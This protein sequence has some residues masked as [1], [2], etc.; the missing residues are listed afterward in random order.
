MKIIR[1][2]EDLYLKELEYSDAEHIFRTID[3]QREYMGEWLPFVDFTKSVDDSAAY[4]K[5]VVDMPEICRE[6]VFTIICDGEFAGLAG[7]KE[8]DR[9]NRKS[10]IGYWLSEPFQGRGIMTKAVKTLVRFAFSELGLNRVMIKC[11]P[12]NM[13]SRN[14]PKRLGFSFEGIER[15]SELVKEGIFR[16]A[17]V[18][19]ILKSEFRD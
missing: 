18:Y 11:A 9:G 17:E 8:T 16:D 19:S 6:Y 13:K 10:E 14:I 4:V 5:S 3:S 7:F 2:D 1:I 12:K 15:D